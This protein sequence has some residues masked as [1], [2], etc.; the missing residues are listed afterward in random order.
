MAGNGAIEQQ[1]VVVG[2]EERQ[3][4]VVVEY[5]GVH[6]GCLAA[7]DVGRIAHNDVLLWQR[8]RGGGEDVVLHDAPA[9]GVVSPC[10]MPCAVGQVVPVP[11]GYSQGGEA[12]VECRD[13]GL[14]KRERKAY[15]YAPG[16]GAYVEYARVVLLAAVCVRLNPLYEFFCFGAWD[17][18]VGR[19]AELMSAEAGKAKYVLDGFARG[20]SVDGGQ[21]RVVGLAAAGDEPCPRFVA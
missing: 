9:S 21:Q 19:D 15:R 14:R 1:R 3:M 13:A 10:A 17:E 8:R 12:D 5:I 20:Q 16:A 7:A 11:A 2:D 4:G 6:A 18:C